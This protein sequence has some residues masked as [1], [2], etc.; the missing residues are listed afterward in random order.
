[1]TQYSQTK[2][3][4]SKKKKSKTKNIEPIFTLKVPKCSLPDSVS[5]RQLFSRT[6]L[7]HFLAEINSDAGAACL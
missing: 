5:L 1:M 4:T 6:L 2:R 7:R 3:N